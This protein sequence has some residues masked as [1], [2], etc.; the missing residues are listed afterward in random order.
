MCIKV[1]RHKHSFSKFAAGH[2][3][4]IGHKIPRSCDVAWLLDMSAS[5]VPIVSR[6]SL[7]F[8]VILSANMFD[9]LVLVPSYHHKR[10]R[11]GKIHLSF[12]VDF[13]SLCLFGCATLTSSWGWV[14]ELVMV[15]FP[16]YVL[17]LCTWLPIGRCCFV[18]RW[19]GVLLMCLGR[20]TFNKKPAGSVD[21]SFH[22]YRALLFVYSLS[23]SRTFSEMSVLK[24]WD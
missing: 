6:V 13:C 15:V 4:P 20:S 8:C 5:K 19:C 9:M 11:Y 3:I 18:L 10:S 23:R 14:G 22:L 17:D 7:L 12:W 21:Y 24:D 2:K 1:S 16:L